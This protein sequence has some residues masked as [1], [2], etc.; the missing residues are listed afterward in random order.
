ME[1]TTDQTNA[2][3]LKE[4][5]KTDKVVAQFW[6]DCSI[7]LKHTDLSNSQMYNQIAQNIKTLT[8]ETKESY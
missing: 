5:Y 6:K 8:D 3:L 4:I 2:Q 7:F 1:S